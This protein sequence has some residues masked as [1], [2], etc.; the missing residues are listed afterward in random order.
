MVLVVV[1]VLPRLSVTV[2]ETVLLPLVLSTPVVGADPVYDLP[3]TVVL[4]ALI[5]LLNA[6]AAVMEIL[7]LDFP[8]TKP[9][10]CALIPATV[11]EMDTAEMVGTTETGTVSVKFLDTAEPIFVLPE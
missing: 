1:A 3:S 9:P 7:A 6:P 5:V 11:S 8:W 10:N 2:M 4:Y